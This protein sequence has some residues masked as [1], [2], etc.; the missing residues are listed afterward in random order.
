MELSLTA[1]ALCLAHA[2]SLG[3][4]GGLLYDLLRPLRHR[5]PPLPAMLCDAVFC[6]LLG[7][8]AFALAMSAGNGRLG[9]VELCVGLAMF[10]LYQNGIRPGCLPAFSNI[11]EIIR[12]KLRFGRLFKK[13]LQKKK[14]NT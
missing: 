11:A 3:L 1:Q 7:A 13:I 9:T 12:K 8:A 14:N 5:L 10:L 4:S 6:L 2:A